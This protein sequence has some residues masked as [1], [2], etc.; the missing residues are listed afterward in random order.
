MPHCEKGLPPFPFC[1]R[2]VMIMICSA[3]WKL[4]KNIISSHRVSTGGEKRFASVEAQNWMISK[5]KERAPPEETRGTS[6]CRHPK[7]TKYSHSFQGDAG[8]FAVA[9]SLETR[10]QRFVGEWLHFQFVRW[11]PSIVLNRKELEPI[12]RRI[13]AKHA[14]GW[15]LTQPPLRSKWV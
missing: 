4:N 10:A 12:P 8:S 14:R 5:R 7:M 13:R 2:R 9:F 15:K 11:I 1:V 6:K 3:V